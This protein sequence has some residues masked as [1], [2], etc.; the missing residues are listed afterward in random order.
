MGLWINLATLRSSPAQPPLV[1]G[2][3][4]GPR[5]IAALPELELEDSFESFDPPLPVEAHD[6]RRVCRAWGVL[7]LLYCRLNHAESARF[8]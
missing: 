2:S 6:P 1:D 7:T 8:Q 5:L 3:L 4:I